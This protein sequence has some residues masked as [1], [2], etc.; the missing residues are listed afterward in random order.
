VPQHP[1]VLTALVPHL[2]RDAK[3]AGNRVRIGAAGNRRTK[4]EADDLDA[5][6]EHELRGERA[7]ESAGQEHQGAHG[8]HRRRSFQRTKNST[9]NCADTTRSSMV[10]G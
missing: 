10:S 6:L 9:N 2:E 5:L 3:L 4:V 7:V 8:R 1:E